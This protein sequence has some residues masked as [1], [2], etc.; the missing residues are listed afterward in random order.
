[1]VMTMRRAKT[2]PDKPDPG[3][4]SAAGP[5]RDEWQVPLGH[6]SILA[7]SLGLDLFIWTLVHEASDAIVYADV[8]GMI[9][10]WNRGA[11]R[12]FGYSA[13][14]VLGRSLEMIIPEELRARHWEAYGQTMRTGKTRYGAGDVLG[15]PALRKDGTIVPIEFTLLPFHDRDGHTLGVAAI[16]RDA[17]RHFAE[18]EALRKELAALRRKDRNGTPAADDQG[19]STFGARA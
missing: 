2:S 11:E 14:E 16:L 5:E 7:A 6:A 8:G 9:R 1:M 18:T 3:S 15:V 4:P 12:I 13:S 19:R 10:F 17:T